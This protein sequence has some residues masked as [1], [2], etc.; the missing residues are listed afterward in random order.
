MC[1][2]SCKQKHGRV[3]INPITGRSN[4]W[5]CMSKDK[6]RY[7]INLKKSFLFQWK[8]QFKLDINIKTFG[9][10]E[11][12]VSVVGV[13]D[14]GPKSNKN[15]W[16]R[17]SAW[18]SVLFLRLCYRSCYSKI[19]K[20]EEFHA[21]KTKKPIVRNLFQKYRLSSSILFAFIFGQI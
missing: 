9:H 12:I 21:Q 13:V 4:H 15:N 14:K 3:Y 8:F 5:N 7:E 11:T 18:S 1:P 17:Y 6:K 2:N 19:S 20:K 16:L 10:K